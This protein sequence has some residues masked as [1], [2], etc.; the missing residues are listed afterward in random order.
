LSAI[1]ERYAA[2]LADVVMERKGAPDVPE[3]LAEFVN[4]YFSSA[5]LRNALESP[6]VD[7]E[8]KI[9]IVEE[10]AEKMKLN[11]AVRNFICLVVDNRRTHMLREM[12]QLLSVELDRRQHIVKLEVTSA[13]KLDDGERTRLIEV[14][15]GDDPKAKVRANFAEDPALLGGLVVRVGSTVYDGS[16]REQLNRLRER[17]ESE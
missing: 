8:V 5:D 13:Q 17:L 4:L 1:A 15:K 16:V 3:D 12:V 7:R 14:F 2:A 6:A 9:K 11:D 10:V